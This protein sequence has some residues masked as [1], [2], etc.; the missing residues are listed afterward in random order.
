[1]LN[2]FTVDLEDWYHGIGIPESDWHL[3]ERRIRIG[4]DKILNILS[5]HKVK[6]TFFVLG[7][8]MEEHPD[9]IRELIREGHEIGCHTY[10]HTE[11]FNLNRENFDHEISK[12]MELLKNFGIMYSGFRAPYFSIDKRSWWAL[13][14]LQKHGFLYDASIY[15][16][17]S[18]RTGIPGYR[19]DIHL[20]EE[21]KL[22]EV[23]ITTFKILNFDFALG[24]AF[25]RILP[26]HYFAGKLKQVNK[27]R[28]GIFYVHPWELDEK[29]PY[30]SSLSA[31]RRIPHY[32][33]L[34]KTE[35]R[36]QQIVQDFEFCKLEDLIKNKQS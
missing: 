4:V 10:S 11:L 17:D 35:K 36:L 3:Y 24:G 28:P 26:Y 9:I 8:V 31:R 5:K 12:C 13:E 33:N 29:H 6:A 19:K 34:G 30:L 7:K 1:M 21:F 25:F 15:P 18:K 23:P 14:V 16:G 27:N 22:W 32:F 2:A 20:I